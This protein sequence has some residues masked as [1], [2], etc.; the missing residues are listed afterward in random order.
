MSKYNVIVNPDT[1]KVKAIIVWEDANFFPIELE[2]MF[3]CLPAPSVA[4]EGVTND[5]KQLVILALK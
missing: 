2:G 1:L 3:C 4:L 5:K